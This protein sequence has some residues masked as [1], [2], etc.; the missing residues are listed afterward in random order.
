M[1]RARTLRVG[2]T[3][4]IGSGKS[5]VAGLL[6]QLGATLVDTDRIARELTVAGGTALPPIIEAFGADAVDA[7]GALDR[8]R[9]RAQVFGDPD[10]RRRLEAI[11]HP[12]IGAEAARQAAASDSPI[13]VFDVPLLV[14]SGRWAALVDRI[15]VV[16]CSVPTQRARVLARAGWNEST[17]DAVIA[18][19]ATRAQR[20]AVADAVIDNDTATLAALGDD[21]AA[22]YRESLALLR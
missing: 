3:G 16:D 4:G 22:L 2:L 19:Q 14:E 6:V 20:R 11:L 13:V 7:S 9:M 8:A 15:W 5:T 12:L 17:V 21:V 18:Q 10:A 1:P